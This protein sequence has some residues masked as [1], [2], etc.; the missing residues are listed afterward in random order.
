MSRPSGR[1]TVLRPLPGDEEL[2]R[3]RV[4]LALA[5]RLW[6]KVAGPWCST[7]QHQIGPDDC[8]D[9]ISPA[10]AGTYRVRD[11]RRRRVV[12]PDRLDYGRINRDGGF[13]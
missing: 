13:E 10:R 1:G 2:P 12:G 3:G 4:V 6:P 11:G 9:F 5:E 8:W 7:P